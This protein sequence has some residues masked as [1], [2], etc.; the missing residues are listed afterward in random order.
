M[1]LTSEQSALAEKGHGGIVIC[2]NFLFCFVFPPMC[3][4]AYCGPSLDLDPVRVV[5]SLAHGLVSRTSLQ[6]YEQ[7]EPTS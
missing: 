4:S 5:R 6:A 1:E 7:D 3:N 2:C